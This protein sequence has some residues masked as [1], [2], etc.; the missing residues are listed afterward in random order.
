MPANAYLLAFHFGPRA[1]CTRTDI[2]DNRVFPLDNDL[3][4]KV[5][6]ELQTK[7]FGIY[8][9]NCQGCQLWQCRQVLRHTGVTI[10]SS[11]I[12]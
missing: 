4:P 10:P 12:T 2:R 6:A 11:E 3:V 1:E 5:R 8:A 9:E 7:L